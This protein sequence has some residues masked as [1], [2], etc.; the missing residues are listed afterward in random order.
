MSETVLQMMT[1]NNIHDIDQIEDFIFDIDH[2]LWATCFVLKE[3]MAYN[4][5]SLIRGVR[6]YNG[7]GYKAEQYADIVLR[8]YG[9][10]CKEY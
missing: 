6:G 9:L 8:I 2:N 7:W 3:K 10:I 4:G 5:Q 1:G